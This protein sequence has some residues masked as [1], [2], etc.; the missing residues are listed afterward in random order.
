[1][2]IQIFNHPEFGG[3]RVIGDADNPQFCLL[4]LCKILG[5]DAN[6]VMRRLDDE[7]TSNHLIIDNGINLSD[8]VIKAQRRD[9]T[10][11]SLK[12]SITA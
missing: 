2:E 6:A 7:V 5:L 9:I 4:N 1:M 3:V 8:T 12:E 10:A 11:I